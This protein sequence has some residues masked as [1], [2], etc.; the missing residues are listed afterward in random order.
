MLVLIIIAG[1]WA[2]LQNALA[3]GGSFVTL[4]ALI[5]SGMSPLAANITSTVALFPGQVTTGWAS[6]NMVRGAG[7]LP[8]RALFAISVVGGALGGL[9]LKTPSSIFSHL[10]PW[11]VLFATVVFAWGSFFRKPGADTQHIGPVTAAIS[12]FL[13]AIYGGY[14]GGGIGFLMMA[15]LTMAGL[16]P[17]HAMST[18]NALAGVMNASAVVLFVTSPHLHWREAIALGGGAIVGGLLGAWAMHRVNERVL[19]IAIVCIGAALTVGL[20]VKPI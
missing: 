3:G 5:V 8:F 10:V 6:R 9:L 16:A 14:F 17:R 7:K 13:I 12:Q 4:P 18:K 19:R 1:L 11:L 15:A 20:F 2:G